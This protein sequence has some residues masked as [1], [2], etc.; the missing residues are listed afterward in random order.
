MSNRSSSLS[1]SSFI[2]GSS[3]SWSGS[4]QELHPSILFIELFIMHHPARRSEWICR[5]CLILAIFPLC[6]HVLAYYYLSDS[7]RP[8]MERLRN[9]P[10][11]QVLLNSISI[12]LHSV[13]T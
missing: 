9:E 1:P 10:E 4:R 8:W 2:V 7:E 11:A 6:S 5:H 12:H 13:V 3:T